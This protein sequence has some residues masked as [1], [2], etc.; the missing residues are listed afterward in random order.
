MSPSTTFSSTRLTHELQQQILA[1]Q[2]L[3]RSNFGVQSSNHEKT[4]AFQ[5]AD[6][7][8]NREIEARLG[9]ADMNDR[10]D[11]ANFSS[12]FHTNENMAND[13]TSRYRLV[14]P[15][16]GFIEIKPLIWNI[17]IT[18]GNANGEYNYQ[19][20]FDGGEVLLQVDHD[21][22]IQSFAFHNLDYSSTPGRYV[23]EIT[24]SYK[25]SY[26]DEGHLN[27]EVEDTRTDRADG[28]WWNHTGEY[29]VRT[30]Y[31][32]TNATSDAYGDSLTT[33]DT[34]N[35]GAHR[36]VTNRFDDYTR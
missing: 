35:N 26:S 27:V 32:W 20:N 12:F 18:S 30:R 7:D 23:F 8:D 2:R 33:E 29:N 5:W 22:A 6:Y 31:H 16:D 1:I 24:T 19:A 25:I 13:L 9:S 15:G 10:F 28:S 21:G 11:V 3:T 36:T 14:N 34:S 17:P 4:N